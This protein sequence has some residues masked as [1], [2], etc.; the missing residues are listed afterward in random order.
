MSKTAG[1]IGKT[2][3]TVVGVAGIV[4]IAIVAPNMIQVFGKAGR[5]TNSQYKRSLNGLK[6]K[7]LV[8]IKKSKGRLQIQLTRRGYKQLAYNNL[9]N[10]RLKRET[11]WDKKWRMI[12]FDVPVSHNNARDEL[13]YLL[14]ELGFKMLQKSAWVYPWPCESEVEQITSVF[15]IDDFVKIILA[16]KIPDSPNLEKHFGI[17]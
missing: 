11:K 13:T 14:K 9:Y 4:A 15:Q 6:N 12:I 5:Y 1:E 8:T 17:T 7:K 10:I 16:D 3:L 2:I